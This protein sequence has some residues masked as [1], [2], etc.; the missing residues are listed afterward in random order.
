MI[1]GAP[2]QV[3]AAGIRGKWRAWRAINYTGPQQNCKVIRPLD[4]TSIAMV[5]RKTFPEL[6]TWVPQMKEPIE[7]HISTFV[8]A[9]AAAPHANAAPEAWASAVSAIWGGRPMLLTA[10]HAIDALEGRVLLLELPDRFEPI[11]LNPELVSTNNGADVA[12][13]LLPDSSFQWGIP[14]LDLQIQREPGID[15]GSLSIFVASG[16]PVRQSKVDGYRSKLLL[17][18]Q[19]YWSFENTEAYDRLGLSRDQFILT[20]FDRKR[21]VQAGIIRAMK[22][23]HGMSGGA[24]WRFWG[25]AQEPP[26]LAREGLAGILTEYRVTPVKCLI[27]ARLAVL[28]ALAR[29][30]VRSQG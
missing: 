22:L 23:P 30:L 26:S 29:Q 9:L 13:L 7:R 25:S 28:Q 6:A 20:S 15:P 10:K 1:L 3:A 21:S 16:F 18:L 8:R 12:G 4:A 19:S 2:E 5:P 24:L 14:F 11:S 17:T 27:A